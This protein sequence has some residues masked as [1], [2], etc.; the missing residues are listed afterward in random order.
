MKPGKLL[1]V[2]DEKDIRNLMHEIFAEEG[3]QVDTAAN[4]V[5]AKQAW[6]QSLPDIM[7]LDVWMPDVDGISLLKDMQQES[8]LEH[9]KVIMMSGHGTI[10]TAIE[11]TKLG[12]YDFLEKPLSLAKLIVTAER[13]MENIR[14][15]QENRQ[16]KQ[17]LPEQFLPI[18]KSKSM[19]SL[20]E[21]VERLAKFTMPVLIEGESG[22]GKHHLA[23]ALHKTSSRKD[24]AIVELSAYDFNRHLE[25]M[26]ESALLQQLRQADMGTL[27]IANIEQLN[28]DAQN[29]LTDLIQNKMVQMDE[30]KIAL[31]IR[32]IALSRG[33]LELA[34]EHGNFRDE[35]YQRL[36]V[37]PIGIPALRQHTEDIPEL[38]EF[39]INHYVTRDGLEYRHFSVP[40]QNTLRQYAWPGNLKELQNLVQRILI[41]GNGEVTDEEVRNYLKESQSESSQ[42]A[43]VDTTLNLKEAKDRLEAAYL[44]QLLRETGGNVAETAKRSGI[45]R[46]N[47]YRKLKNLGIDPKNPI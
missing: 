47:L 7:F 39:F 41:L 37:M 31:D 8:L 16:L 38:L 44:S 36:K 13:A 4:G 17:K 14:L 27:V 28:L 22:S 29:I 43:N 15:N 19:V 26:Q 11:A 21:T 40:A 3:Y 18:G 5:Q 10:E 6:R 24:G 9:T 30:Q 42:A 34:V 23:R 35:L 1:I 25:Q 2:D 46:T 45:D 32:I 20:R 33:E 12:A